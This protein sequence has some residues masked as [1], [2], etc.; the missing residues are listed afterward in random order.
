MTEKHITVN[1]EY[2]YRNIKMREKNNK[3]LH[4]QGYKYNVHNKHSSY[5]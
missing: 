2:K 3:C 1:T 5:T 4:K